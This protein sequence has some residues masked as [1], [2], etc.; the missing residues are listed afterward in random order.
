MRI[1]RGGGLG[2]RASDAV[3]L[4][5]RI[6]SNGPNP[7]R[8]RALCPYLYD[9]VVLHQSTIFGLIPC[10]GTV[11]VIDYSLGQVDRFAA[12]LIVGALVPLHL[13]RY[14]TP[15]TAVDAALTTMVVL[16][17]GMQH[18][19]GEGTTAAHGQ[20]VSV[21]GAL[22]LGQMK[23]ALMVEGAIDGVLLRSFVEE[24]LVPV[25]QPVDTV[26]LDNPP[27]HNGKS[28]EAAIYATG[29]HCSICPRTHRTYRRSNSVGQKSHI[30]C[31]VPAPS[32]CNRCKKP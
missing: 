10:D 27:I 20:N 31:A 11:G 17:I 25:L 22:S 18:M 13:R 19:P 26:F 16:V 30:H 2:N 1:D 24:L 21:L 7:P 5:F 14:P 4:G 12:P 29:R 32:R 3:A 23:T 9:P 28:I 8:A 6:E 15:D